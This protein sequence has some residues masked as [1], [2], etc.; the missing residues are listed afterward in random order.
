ML[1]LLSEVRVVSDIK[2]DRTT[3]LE[4]NKSYFGDFAPKGTTMDHK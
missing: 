4:E 1:W 3:L 2:C